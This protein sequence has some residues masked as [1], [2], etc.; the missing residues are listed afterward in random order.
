MKL[1]GNHAPNF[2][3]FSKHLSR[4]LLLFALTFFSFSLVAQGGDHKLGKV[5]FKNNCAS[6]HNKNMKDDLTGPALGGFQERWADYPK[7]DLYSW[8]RNSQAMI[9]SGHQ[10][11]SLIHI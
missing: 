2:L 5:L 6:C 9:S 4:Y 7:E 8:I 11:L 10:R 3:V 1:I